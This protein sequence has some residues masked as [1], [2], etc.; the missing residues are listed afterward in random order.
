MPVIHG[1]HASP[2]VRKVEI[3]LA[4]KEV[5]Y[6]L[7]TM[8]PAPPKPAPLL[9]M[10]PLGKVPVLEDDGLIVPDSSAICAYLER[11]HPTPS[12][13]PADPR[14]YARALWIEE[15][16]DTALVEATAPVFFERV[17]KPMILNQPT[18]EAVVRRAIDEAAP[19]V[20]AY[21][22]GIAP[23][24][25]YLFG[26]ALSIAD[27]AVASP[28]ANYRAAGEDID[29]GRYPRFA[30]L[31]DRVLARPGVAPIVAQLGSP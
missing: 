8:I 9:A 26:E 21:L 4:E 3:A 2:F 25:A 29:A 16:A 10:N 24:D 19:V 13:Y 22:E 17:A 31:V 7:K 18:D 23:T 15:Y 30:A 20:F 6:D 5:P 1:F 27:I 14:D 28:I 11:K 12:L